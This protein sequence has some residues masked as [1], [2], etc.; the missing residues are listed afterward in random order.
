M[1][2]VFDALFHILRF[3]KSFVLDLSL[4]QAPFNDSELAGLSF[5]AN[6]SHGNVNDSTLID[7]VTYRMFLDAW[8]Q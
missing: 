6:P 4:V 7:T 2:V 8:Y 5:L 1:Q 3:S